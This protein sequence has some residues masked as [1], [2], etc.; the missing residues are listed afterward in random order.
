MPRPLAIIATKAAEQNGFLTLA[1][2]D[3]L[4]WGRGSVARLVKHG[5]LQREHSGT[6]SFGHPNRSRVGRWH[7]AVLA[8]GPGAVLSHRSA[9]RL[10]GFVRWEGAAPDIIVAKSKT[11]TQ[12]AVATHRCRFL[13]EDVVEING[14]RVTTPM[15]T[16][17][18]LADVVPER[19]LAD[20]FD[21][22]MLLALYDQTALDDVL[23]RARGRR[24]LRK[25]RRVLADLTDSPRPF[26]S[27]LERLAF[28]ILVDHGLPA[29]EVNVRI[30]VAPGR[31]RRADLYY[32][33]LRLVIEVDGPH[34]RLPHR[35]RKDMV[36]DTELA[37][38]GD[39]VERFSDTLIMSDPAGFA[40]AVAAAREQR[41]QALGR[42]VA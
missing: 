34:H 15:R 5:V 27:G 6:Y 24:G 9:A 41:A 28:R 10:W 14:M 26:E 13:E 8:G 25:L 7:A 4:G 42:R 20:A 30:E 40:A 33:D 21:Q 11:L 22:A 35:R 1:D 2:L 32:R 17:V 18:D 31:Y 37:G 36:R 29:P 39:H 19:V 38:V 23:A 3:Q 12:T 16:L